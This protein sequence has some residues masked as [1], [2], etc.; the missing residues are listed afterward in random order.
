MRS[1]ITA[2]GQTVIPAPIRERFALSPSQRLEWLVEADGTIRVVPVDA[3]PVKAFRGRGK[4]GA[5][6]R[7]LD[8]RR[9]EA[10]LE[11]G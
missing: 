7:L 2:R 9:A 10:S 3:S 1:T 5:S 4:A 8:D 6:Q 11:A